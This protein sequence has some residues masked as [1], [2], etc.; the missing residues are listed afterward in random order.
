MLEYYKSILPS[1]MTTIE[2]QE[3]TNSKKVEKKD[4]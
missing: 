3:A 1:K 4:N 2:V